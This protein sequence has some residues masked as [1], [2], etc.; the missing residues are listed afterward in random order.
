M[1]K[2]PNATMDVE[3]AIKNTK[4]ALCGKVIKPGQRR[5]KVRAG[6]SY[7]RSACPACIKTAFNKTLKRLEA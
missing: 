2:I 7:P 3:I 5:V 4:C 1:V 6:N